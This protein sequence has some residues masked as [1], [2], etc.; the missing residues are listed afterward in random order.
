MVKPAKGVEYERELGKNR[1]TKKKTKRRMRNE[2][3]KS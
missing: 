2:R 1:E 3:Y